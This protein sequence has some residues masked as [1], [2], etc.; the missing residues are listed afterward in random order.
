MERLFSQAGVSLYKT[1]MV[2]CRAFT[3]SLPDAA[4]GC[5]E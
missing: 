5:A 3:E 2:R 1:L 4:P